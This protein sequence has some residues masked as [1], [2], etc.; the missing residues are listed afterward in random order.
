MKR[1]EDIMSLLG[2]LLLV[3]LIWAGVV[4]LVHYVFMP[5]Y[6][7]QGKEIRV[8]DVRNL[9]LGEARQIY[10]K[11]GFRLIVDDERFVTEIPPGTILDQFPAP[12]GWTKKGRRIHLAVS[13]GAPTTVVPHIIGVPKDDA[14]FAVQGAGL[15]LASIEYAFSDSLFDGLVLSQI[16]LSGN[17]VEKNTQFTM[18]VSLGREPNRFIVPRVVNLPEEQARYLILKAG[19]NVGEVTYDSYVRR[20]SGNVVLQRPS[21]GLTV[22]KGDSIEIVVNQ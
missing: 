8:P 14:V 6:T 21:A 19:L 20:R 5:M 1:P 3:L 12:G 9:T 16:P 17:I 13:A 4:V 18:T 11:K 15:K 7:R 10:G 22:A 2:K